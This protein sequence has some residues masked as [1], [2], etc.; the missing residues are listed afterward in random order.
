VRDLDEHERRLQVEKEV[1]KKAL[2]KRVL[3]LDERERRVQHEKEVDDL[4]EDTDKGS[5]DQLGQ[6]VH[7]GTDTATF[8]ATF[9]NTENHEENARAIFK[10]RN[11]NPNA[12]TKIESTVHLTDLEG[13]L[14]SIKKGTT[15]SD[16]F[17]IMFNVKG[18]KKRKVGGDDEAGG[19]SPPS[20]KPRRSKKQPAKP[21]T[22]PVAQDTAEQPAR[23]TVNTSPPPPRR[24]ARVNK[25]K[26]P[27]LLG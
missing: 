2:E 24:S 22:S 14:R 20:K 7:N 15:V 12:A 16:E 13:N 10:L 6:E 25:G 8:C 18:S 11:F 4:F 9:Q 19:P 17:T 21:R 27:R 23:A 26:N 1:T 5:G 3:D